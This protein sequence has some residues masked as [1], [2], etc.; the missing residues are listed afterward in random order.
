M[1]KVP[2]QLTVGSLIKMLES[3]LDRSLP[4]AFCQGIYPSEFWS[5]RGYYEDLA[6]GVT[7][8]PVTVGEWLEKL[9]DQV[10]VKHDG[11]KGGEYEV[12]MQTPLWVA[13]GNR[14]TGPAITGVKPKNGW[15]KLCLTHD[16]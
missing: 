6:V 2:N 9:K 16:D 14:D 10:G 12:T 5:Y 3:V 8:F 13:A 15:V 1:I 4:L 11:W 7:T